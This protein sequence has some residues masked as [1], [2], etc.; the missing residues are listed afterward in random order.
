LVW[1]VNMGNLSTLEERQTEM[2]ERQTTLQP[3]VLSLMPHGERHYSVSEVAKLWSLSRDSVRRLFRRERGVLVIGSRY[4]TLRI[5]ESV[6]ERVHR[7]LSNTNDLQNARAYM[8]RQGQAVS[9]G[10][11]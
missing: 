1:K 3:S 6:L 8:S 11:H 7:R 4:A 5:P 10:K 2:R 9:D